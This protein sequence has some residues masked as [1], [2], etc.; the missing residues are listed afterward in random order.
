MLTSNPLGYASR[1][2]ELRGCKESPGM[3]SAGRRD[4]RQVQPLNHIDC[5][6]DVPACG[7]GT[8]ARLVSAI[9]KSLCDVALHTGQA[10][11]EASLEEESA[12]S[13]AQVHFGVNGL[14]WRKSDLHLACH[15]CYRAEETSRPAGGEQLLRV[16]ARGGVPGGNS[17]MSSRSSSLWEA[18][19]R[20]PLVWTL[21]VYRTLSIFVMVGS[22]S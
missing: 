17:V 3:T 19:S 11:V 12:I 9:Y 14:V 15:A 13:C 22:L 2:A 7:L 4:L 6:I 1:R 10:Y 18:P 5:D 21:A 8:R 16:G 20:P